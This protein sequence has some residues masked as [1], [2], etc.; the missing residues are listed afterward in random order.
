MLPTDMK[1]FHLTKKQIVYTSSG[2]LREKNINVPTKEREEI[3][4]PTQNVESYCQAE[5]VSEV[6]SFSGRITSLVEAAH[7]TIQN[8]DISNMQQ[9][10][11][12][13]KPDS[14][15]ITG[16]DS[17]LEEDFYHIENPSVNQKEA[18]RY[19]KSPI[20]LTS[21]DEVMISHQ[22][23]GIVSSNSNLKE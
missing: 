11:E 12:E 13:R 10:E 6:G 14:V 7:A 15:A 17:N 23:N 2:K 4:N 21:N 8:P 20:N 1:E 9:K 16:S 5:E 18:T 19:H 3:P 22:D